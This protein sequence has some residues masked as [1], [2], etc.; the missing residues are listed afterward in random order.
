MKVGG[1]DDEVH[2]DEVPVTNLDSVWL[3]GEVTTFEKAENEIDI[4]AIDGKAMTRETQI[5]FNVANVRK[6]LASAMFVAKAGNGIWIDANG[7]NI[8]NV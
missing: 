4:G 2:N 7:G 1:I 5:E 8:Q 3:V 6:P